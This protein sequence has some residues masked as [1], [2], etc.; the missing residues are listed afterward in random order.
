MET[1]LV[2]PRPPVPF[3]N[4]STY[5]ALQKKPPWPKLHVK[6]SDLS[7]PNFMTPIRCALYLNGNC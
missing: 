4:A 1:L 5:T 2:P 6:L 3:L 7:L